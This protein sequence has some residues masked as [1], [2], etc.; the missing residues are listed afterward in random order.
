M[1]LSEAE[2]KYKITYPQA[3]RKVYESGAMPWLDYNKNWI[4]KHINTIEKNSWAFFCGLQ[5]Y[6]LPFEDIEKSIT[7]FENSLENN[8]EY[9]Y[10]S[11][12]LNPRYRFFPF[13][14]ATRDLEIYY[15]FAADSENP[16]AE[17]F[18]VIYSVKDVVMYTC[19]KNFRYFVFNL[20]IRYI[21]QQR[22]LK[23]EINPAIINALM[24]FTGRKLDN[25]EITSNYDKLLEKHAETEQVFF[26][27]L[28]PAEEID[29]SIYAQ[30]GNRETIV[31][32]KKTNSAIIIDE[33]RYIEAGNKSFS[34]RFKDKTETYNKSL[35]FI[36]NQLPQDKFYRCH[37]SYIAGFKHI[38]KITEDG[39]IFDN[40]EKAS[41]SRR[42]MTEFKKKFDEY[43]RNKSF[44][45]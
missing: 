23:E 38:A 10:G 15:M 14:K 4:N 43:K 41:L 18:V 28:I 22:K 17:P 7:A 44:A 19:A 39:V 2:S 3:F 8:H 12:R 11:V 45:V 25:I 13:A 6:P 40:G 33:I 42:K 9:K 27:H 32:D 26:P 16:K 35:S 29:N 24:A 5:F 36:E 34:V 1:V 31:I 37:K 20:M 21:K 30:N